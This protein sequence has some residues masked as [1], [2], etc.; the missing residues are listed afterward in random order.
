MRIDDDMSPTTN[1]V[2]SFYILPSTSWRQKT[3]YGKGVSGMI[4]LSNRSYDLIR[5]KQVENPGTEIQAT[6]RTMA[7]GKRYMLHL[8][9]AP[10][11]PVGV[12][13]QTIKLKTDSTE[14][15]E[16]VLDLE[17]EVTP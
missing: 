11:L 4:S 5:I 14:M 7:P 12:Y 15:P 6:L 16:I 8:Q 1:L 13:R 9:S 3:P 2:G 17:L 10:T